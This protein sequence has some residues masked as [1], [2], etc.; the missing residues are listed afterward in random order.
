MPPAAAAAPARC[1]RERLVPLGLIARL[2]AGKLQ[3]GSRHLDAEAPSP[4]V[5]VLLVR[6]H[7]DH[8]TVDD[9]RHLLPCDQ[10]VEDLRLITA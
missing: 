7:A 8:I 2:G 1:L 10:A 5:L 3:L 9:D 4:V 6:D